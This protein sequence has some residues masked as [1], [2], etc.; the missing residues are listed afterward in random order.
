MEM[1]NKT[2]KTTALRI[3]I[4]GP[5]SAGKTTLGRAL[6]REFNGFF[7]EEYARFYLQNLNRSYHAHDVLSIAENQFQQNQA[8]RPHEWIFLDTEM[9]GAQIWYTEKYGSTHQKIEKLITN[10]HIDLYILCMPDI[11]W[12]YDPLRENPH[13]R[14]RLFVRYESELASR[15]CHYFIAKGNLDDRLE[16]VKEKI[17][18]TYFT[19]QSGFKG[20]D[21]KP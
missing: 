6:A 20:L 12:E 9:I 21:K 5:E 16:A 13:D 7:V 14:D 17:R 2:E 19:N 18:I 15:K 1:E 10:Q 8:S 4:T 11:P 3:A